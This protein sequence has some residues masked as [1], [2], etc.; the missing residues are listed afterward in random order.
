VYSL[1]IN[2]L[3]PHNSTTNVARLNCKV[4]NTENTM[5]ANVT[6]STTNTLSFGEGRRPDNIRT[7][8][9][10]KD[11]ISKYNTV[12]TN[13]DKQTKKKIETM[14]K[15]GVLLSNRSNDR[16]TVLDNL[17]LIASSKRAQ[18][19]SSK[20]I[21]KNTVDA[22]TNPYSITQQ[23]GDIPKGY[24]VA[25]V[26][27]FLDGKQANSSSLKFAQEEI[28]IEHSGTCVAAS[29]EF[30]LAKNYPAEFARFAAGLS[31]PDLAVEKTIQLKNLTDNVM[32][33]V[34]LLNAFEIPYEM[35]D[36][37][38]AVLKIA[39]DK[40]ALMR[41]T[42]QTTHRDKG[43][44]SSLDVLMQSAFMNVGSEQSYNSLS[45]KRK[46]KFNQNDK[47]L[48]EFEKTFTESIVENENK[49]SV[50]Y[51]KVDENSKLVGYETDFE[52]IKQQITASLNMGH[53][54]IIGYTQTDEN[55]VI[56]NGHEITITDVKYDKNGKMIF[57]CNDTDDGLSKPI[58]YSED[59]L[60]P[61]IHHAALPQS[62][63]DGKMEDD[64]D[65]WSEGLRV[66]QEIKNN[67]AA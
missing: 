14:L 53:D 43:E 16:S 30:N 41:A 20:E 24:Q 11:E 19:L 29:I 57:V 67:K 38:N 58:T 46:G 33:S 34:W 7:S 23:F 31:S 4:S 27:L 40:N 3:Q 66:Y 9:N 39:P 25:A 36:Y 5:P 42:I 64:N 17:Y 15:N 44:R 60:V 63:L 1:S 51:Q 55:N 45:D 61:K 6:T 35:K 62:V 13:V 21:I 10:N 47:G 49:T 26:N 54:V 56:I 18:G 12:L 28:N 32:D 65:I 50:T 59:Y 37:N 48:I 2:N 22:I 8:L 52:T